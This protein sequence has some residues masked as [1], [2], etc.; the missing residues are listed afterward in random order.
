MD[1]VTLISHIRC[2]QNNP[3]FISYT[4]NHCAP[5]S[6]LTTCPYI[7][8]TYSAVV[9]HIIL[10]ACT[11]VPLYALCLLSMCHACAVVC[12]K[13]PRLH[14]MLFSMYPSLVTCY[15]DGSIDTHTTSMKTRKNAL[16]IFR[17][18]VR[19]L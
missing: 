8:S 16:A 13:T 5:K 11:R 6:L 7:V 4:Q 9:Y 10:Y 3:S 2:L 12:I 15:Y 19:F 14:Y 18:S 1:Q 17:R